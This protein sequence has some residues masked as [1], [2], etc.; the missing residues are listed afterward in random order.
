MNIEFLNL[1]SKKSKELSK[2]IALH[3]RY[4]NIIFELKDIDENQITISVRQDESFHENNIDKRDLVLKTRETFKDFVGNRKVH[5]HATT[6]SPIEHINHQWVKEQM[7]RYG[8]KN[9]H[10]ARDTGIS[11]DVISRY[12]SPKYGEMTKGAKAMF[13]Y[14]FK[15][16][17]L[18]QNK[19]K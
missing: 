18:L 17:E 8:I 7:A 15:T 3:K 11:Q 12:T 1:D 9:K 19:L 6:P 14:Y 16:K 2:R 13:F 10:L 5:V 4:S